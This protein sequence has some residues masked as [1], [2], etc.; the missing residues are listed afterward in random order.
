[1]AKSDEQHDPIEQE[2]KRVQLETAR[3]QLDEQRD[4]NEHLKATKAEKSRRNMER[5]KQLRAEVSTRTQISNKCKHRQGGTPKNP[6]NGKGPT[7]LNIAMMPDGFTKLIMCSVCRLRVFTPHPRNQSTKPRDGE[8]AAQAKN[9]AGQYQDDLEYY[10]RLMEMAKD[11]LTEE[12]AQ[13]MDCG[14]TIV[15]RDDEGREVLPTRPCDT[16]ANAQSYS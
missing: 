12:G 7:A 4:R 15:L 9:R 10:N 1:M 5:Q 8:T 13:E 14:T 6:L 2:I 16:Y 11:N 3:L